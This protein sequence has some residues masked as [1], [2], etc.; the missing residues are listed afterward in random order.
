M[1]IAIV[2]HIPPSVPPRRLPA[3]AGAAAITIVLL[4]PT[5]S[6]LARI[7]SFQKRAAHSG[8]PA[9]VLRLRLALNVA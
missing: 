1:L 3:S 8:L 5:A 9:S 6:L 7:A 2:V 4:R